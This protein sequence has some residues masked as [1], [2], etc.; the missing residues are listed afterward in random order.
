MKKTHLQI[1]RCHLYKTVRRGLK[2][3][4]TSS[5][6]VEAGAFYI[7]LSAG[8]F[9]SLAHRLQLFHYTKLP[10]AGERAA[11]APMSGT[12]VAPIVQG[13]IVTHGHV[14]ME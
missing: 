3:R 6:L 9:Y 5:I 1:E 8:A 4:I 13:P 11:T 10:T 7:S 12:M 2:K 14:N